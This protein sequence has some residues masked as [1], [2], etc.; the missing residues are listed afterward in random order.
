[1]SEKDSLKDDEFSTNDKFKKSLRQI[2]TEATTT[3]SFELQTKQTN[4]K[5]VFEIIPQ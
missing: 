2:L 4:T 1:M 3:Q 5:L